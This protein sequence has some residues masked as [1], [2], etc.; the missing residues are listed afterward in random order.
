MSFSK[1]VILV[2]DSLLGHF[3]GFSYSSKGS[4]VLPSAT[5]SKYFW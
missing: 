5:H 3:R 2:V 4:A 1:P